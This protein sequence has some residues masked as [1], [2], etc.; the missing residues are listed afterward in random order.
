MAYQCV[1]QL[2]LSQAKV[3]FWLLMVEFSS[4]T[5]ECISIPIQVIPKYAVLLYCIIKKRSFH[6]LGS[7]FS[8]FLN[9]DS[10]K[11]TRF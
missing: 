6:L 11:K 5:V 1:A 2:S 4:G 8:Q 9:L 10:A 3:F 7:V